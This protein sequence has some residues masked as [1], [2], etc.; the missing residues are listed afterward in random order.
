MG[1]PHVPTYTKWLK[2]NLKKNDSIAFDG[3]VF[4]TKS[5]NKLTESFKDKEIEIV[6]KFDL[7][8]EL[9]NSDRPELSTKPILELLH[10]SL[11]VPVYLKLEFVET[12]LHGLH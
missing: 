12:Y 6:S 1:I 9:W 3:K 2:D 5:V 11:F 4:S 7:V 10:L 8:S